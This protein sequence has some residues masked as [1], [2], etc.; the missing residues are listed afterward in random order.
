MV[1][2]QCFKLTIFFFVAEAV[3]DRQLCTSEENNS[4]LIVRASKLRAV[5][6][7]ENWTRSSAIYQTF[8]AKFA[9]YCLREVEITSDLLRRKLDFQSYDMYE[10]HNQ[11]I[12]RS[13]QIFIRIQEISFDMPVHSAL[14]ALVEEFISR[15]RCIRIA[16]PLILFGKRKIWASPSLWLW[17]QKYM[18]DI[19]LQPLARKSMEHPHHC[20]FGEQQFGISTFQIKAL[21][22]NNLGNPAFRSIFGEKSLGCSSSL[23]MIKIRPLSLP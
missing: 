23:F 15:D 4:Y 22:E 13:S 2:K 6:F 3:R 18:K 19:S 12:P 14:R 10:D 11:I 5:R 7:S 21:E 9:L 20:G 8:E 16:I 17:R 1:A